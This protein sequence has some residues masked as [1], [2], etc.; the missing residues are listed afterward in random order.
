MTCN[1]PRLPI[2][3][4]TFQARVTCVLYIAVFSYNII[5]VMGLLKYNITLLQTS[6]SEYTVL[7]CQ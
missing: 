7:Q 5:T 1:N 2:V 3:R 6:Y 4:D